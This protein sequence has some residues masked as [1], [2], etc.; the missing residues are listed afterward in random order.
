MAGRSVALD[1]F[2]R[3]L[4][5]RFFHFNSCIY[6]LRMGL[7]SDTAEL[8]LGHDKVRLMVNPLIMGGGK[9]LFTDVKERHALYVKGNIQI[10]LPIFPGKRN[11]LTFRL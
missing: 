7:I 1:M 10:S 4:Q 9:Y 3:T 6:R 5:R 2:D 11:R 8:A